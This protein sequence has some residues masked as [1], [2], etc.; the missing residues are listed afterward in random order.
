MFNLMD[1][2]E[3]TGP[4][5]AAYQARRERD[6]IFDDPD[7]VPEWFVSELMRSRLHDT[8]IELAKLR[9]PNSSAAEAS[10]EMAT[11]WDA[12]RTLRAF[13]EHG[14]NEVG[15][16]EIVLAGLLGAME[17]VSE[18]ERREYAAQSDD[19][20]RRAELSKEKFLVDMARKQLDRRGVLTWGDLTVVQND[21]L[22]QLHRKHETER[23]AMAQGA[24]KRA[25]IRAEARGEE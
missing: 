23:L 17:V 22:E 19:M 18:R 7:Y 5:G 1:V 4:Y 11:V 10:V 14:N 6:G 2:R 8:E 16:R 24:G 3:M 21:E 15:Q 12:L 13:L 9:P 20:K 25:K